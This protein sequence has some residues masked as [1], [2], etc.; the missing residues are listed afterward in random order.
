MMSTKQAS[1]GKTIDGESV[2]LFGPADERKMQTDQRKGK[3]DVRQ[4]EDKKRQGNGRWMVW[5][6]KVEDCSLRLYFWQN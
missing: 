4:T 6:R 3:A 1:Q 5:K 2:L